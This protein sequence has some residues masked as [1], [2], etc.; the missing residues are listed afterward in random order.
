M[1]NYYFPQINDIQQNLYQTPVINNDNN[2]QQQQNQFPFP[3]NINQIIPNNQNIQNQILPLLYPDQFLCQNPLYLL[4][5][6]LLFPQTNQINY[7][8]QLI[9]EQNLRNP[10]EMIMNN[11]INNIYNKLLNTQQLSVLNENLLA[12]IINNKNLINEQNKQKENNET[13]ETLHTNP[14]FAG[15]IVGICICHGAG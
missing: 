1:D 15:S 11:S 5:R 2:I 14:A 13:S 12:N 8:N 4:P 10:S 9:A 6:L 7:L 3:I